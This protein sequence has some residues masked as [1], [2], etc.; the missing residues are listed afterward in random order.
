MTPLERVTERVNRLGDPNKRG[1]PLPL[2]T[3]AEFFDGN[4]AVGSIGCN[5]PG[6]PSPSIMRELCEKIAARADVKDLRILV[7]LFDE[8]D[9]WPFSDTIFVL[10]A[11]EPDVVRSW[12]P[13]ELAPDEVYVGEFGDKHVE[14]YD[15]PPGT[16]PIGCWWD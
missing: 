6:S 1:T 7:T 2:L 5:L 8:P 16:H 14:P 15:I 13:E 10:T 9:Y 11:V 12:F 3:I 4:D